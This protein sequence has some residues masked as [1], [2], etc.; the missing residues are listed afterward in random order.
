M[1]SV[2]NWQ[3]MNYATFFFIQ[4]LYKKNNFNRYCIFLIISACIEGFYGISC[5]EI[6]GHCHEAN[7]CHYVNG[8]CL[9]GCAAG[10]EGDVCKT[11]M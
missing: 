4:N 6:C 9:T 10:Y 7:Q 3:D 11:R 2:K 8:T 5:K 1:N